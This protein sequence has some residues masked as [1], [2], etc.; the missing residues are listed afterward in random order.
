VD[1]ILDLTLPDAGRICLS[2][3][4]VGTSVES[5]WPDLKPLSGTNRNL[6][7][8]R[9]GTRPTSRGTPLPARMAA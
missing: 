3:A 4:M 6:L 7:Q 8:P 2:I 5:H 1:Q 9:L